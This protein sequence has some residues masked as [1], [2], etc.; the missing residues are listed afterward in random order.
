MF[1]QIKKTIQ[2]EGMMCEHCE[3]RVKNALEALEQVKKAEVSHK[4]GTAVVTCREEISDERLRAVIEEQ[5]Y[6]VVR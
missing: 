1:G 4:K 6:T 5:G 3:A 2:I